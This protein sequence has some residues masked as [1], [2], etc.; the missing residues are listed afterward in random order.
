LQKEFEIAIRWTAFPLH[1]GIPP[2]GLA[3]EDLFSGRPINIQQMSSHLERTA[4]ELALPFGKREKTYNSR[5]A[6]ELGK[7]AES[8][9]KGDAFHHAVFRAYFAEG[10][11]IGDMATLIEVGKTVGLSEDGI[12]SIIETR[13]FKDA[14]DSDWSRS[15]ELGVTAVP[16][17]RVDG[18]ILVG[19]QP[20]HVLVKFLES[21]DITRRSALE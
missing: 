5:L 4:A 2:E 15:N 12:R 10:R 18:R 14:V 9:G 16:T 20:Y 19:A 17:F 1:P 11:N 21:G 7:W 3:L 6:Q 8:Q 13:A